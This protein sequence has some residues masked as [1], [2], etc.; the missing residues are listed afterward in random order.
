M[1]ARID[2]GA[3]LGLCEAEVHTL[4]NAGGVVTDDVVRS[5]TISQSVLGT[6]E[7]MV[8]KHTKCGMLQKETDI[9][10]AVEPLTGQV[11]DFPLDTFDDLDEAVR[12]S[13]RRARERPTIPYRDQVRGFVYDVS[14]GRVRAVSE[15]S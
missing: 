8:I 11:P 2:V 15:P 13:C 4:R 12:A 1:D 3:I 7:V 14:T 9:V 6:R 10:R 5:L